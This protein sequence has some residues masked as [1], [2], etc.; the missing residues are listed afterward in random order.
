M[1]R[2]LAGFMAAAGMVVTV[3]CGQSDAGITTSVKTRLAADDT[4]KAYQVD[5]DTQNRVVTLSGAVEHTAARER[6]LM[7]AR[8]TDGV[9]DVIDQ[10][11]VNEA[12]ATSGIDNDLDIDA[13]KP[14]VDVDVDVNDDV[15]NRARRGA[16][17]TGNAAERG[18]EATGNAAER[19]GE[20]TVDGAKKAGKATVDGAKKV[21]GAIRDAVTDDDR[22]SDRDGK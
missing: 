14:D 7:I 20:A 10:I 11:T 15:E 19:V 17:A 9:R 2:K 12:A 21:G 22:D 4:V 5:V 18:A 1:V 13:D 3:A 8:E 16:E 6:A